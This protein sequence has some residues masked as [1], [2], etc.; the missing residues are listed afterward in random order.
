MMGF[1]S[2][3]Q[4]FFH[5]CAPQIKIQKH[6][7]TGKGKTKQGE[8]VY[9]EQIHEYAGKDEDND[10]L[11]E[12]N[13]LPLIG[14]YPQD[15]LKMCDTKTPIKKFDEQTTTRFHCQNQ[16]KNIGCGVSHM[17]DNGDIKSFYVRLKADDATFNKMSGKLREFY[18]EENNRRAYRMI[19]ESL[20]AVRA[21]YNVHFFY[22]E[23]L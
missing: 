14:Y 17:P 23:K 12:E 7:T 1:D 21:H 2:I 19:P 4:F 3:D 10:Q 22:Y 6:K 15:Y 18:L 13:V 20:R 16:S 11:S 5:C 8:P 9:M